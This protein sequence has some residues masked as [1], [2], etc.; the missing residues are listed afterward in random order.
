MA[1][2]IEEVEV[3]KPKLFSPAPGLALED[4]R[5]RRIERIWRRGKLTIW[6]LSDE[7]TL[8]VHLRSD[9]RGQIGKRGRGRTEPQ[10]QARTVDQKTAT[11]EV[12]GFGETVEDAD[13]NVKGIGRGARD[14]RHPVDGAGG[15]RPP[16]RHRDR[17]VLEDEIRLASAPPRYL[18]ESV[19]GSPVVLDVRGDP[20]RR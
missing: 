9:K 1:T 2:L 14:I 4:L 17:A 3:H 20:H 18:D 11:W 19:Q 15:G 12:T 7:L 5:G 6:E 13:R 10:T 16:A 8:I